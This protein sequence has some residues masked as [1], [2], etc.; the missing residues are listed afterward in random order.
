[1]TQEQLR[2]Q[3]LAGIITEGQYKA[4]L[5]ENEDISTIED[6]ESY[7]K[8]MFPNSKVTLKYDEEGDGVLI[9]GIYVS[10]GAYQKWDVYVEATDEEKSFQSNEELVGYLKSKLG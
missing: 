10:E 3:M 4:M 9:D 5:N 1:M 2:M 7:L 8:S 6:L